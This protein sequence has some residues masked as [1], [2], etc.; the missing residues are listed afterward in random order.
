ME[1]LNGYWNRLFLVEVEVEFGLVGSIGKR[2]LAIGIFKTYTTHLLLSQIG[3]CGFL[4]H[5]P[6]KTLQVPEF[7]FVR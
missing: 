5:E 1:L 7:G 6:R 3:A 4:P 2:M